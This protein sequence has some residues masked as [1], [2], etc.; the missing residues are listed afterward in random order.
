[1]VQLTL[2]IIVVLDNYMA[3]C[4]GIIASRANDNGENNKTQRND[5]SP[6]P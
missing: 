5:Y 6:C 1:M 3:M 2:D 4:G